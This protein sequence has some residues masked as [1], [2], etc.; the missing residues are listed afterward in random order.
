MKYNKPS[1]DLSSFEE[2]K[3]KEEKIKNKR[4]EKDICKYL[5]NGEEKIPL[6]NKKSI[7]KPIWKNKACGY[8]CEVRGCDSYIT[9]E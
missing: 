9:K 7:F 6:E 4:K 3:E 1:F 2:K 8:L 5:G